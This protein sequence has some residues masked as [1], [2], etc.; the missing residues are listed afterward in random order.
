M[1]TKFILLIAF[2]SLSSVTFAQNEKGE[3]FL[4]LMRDY[5]FTHDKTLVN[6]TIDMINGGLWDEGV[7]EM[8]FKAF[9]GALFAINPEVKAEFQK[10]V[11]KIK[12]TEFADL[13]EQVFNSS[14]DDIYANAPET[15]DANEMICYSYYA[16]GDNK[17]IDQLLT[18]AAD[19]EERKDLDKYMV[20]ANALWWLA[21]VRDE[22][23]LIKEYLDTKA[24]NKYAQI[25]LKSRAYD[26]KNQ[27]LDVLAEQKKK[28]I[29]K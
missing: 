24:G 15:I 14:I 20:G 21:T 11:I 23:I 17:Y 28:G 2:I 8:R 27:Q 4:K 16:T 19:S 22:H 5:Y 13:F 9:Y 1:K 3:K 18:K 7:F 6:Q 29:W 26:L 10:K 25:A 12:S